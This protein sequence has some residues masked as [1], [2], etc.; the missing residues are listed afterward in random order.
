M[1]YN[2][3]YRKKYKDIKDWL[4]DNK[5]EL[6]VNS[7]NVACLREFKGINQELGRIGVINFFL[8]VKLDITDVRVMMN[9]AKKQ[10]RLVQAVCKD[11]KKYKVS[12]DYKSAFEYSIKKLKERLRHSFFITK[13]N[14][15]M[16]EYYPY[17]EQVGFD[18][19]LTFE[20]RFAEEEDTPI[21][22]LV[23]EIEAWNKEHKDE[24]KAHV[25]SVREE[26]EITE[27]FR[28]EKQE[29]TKQDKKLDRD[30][31]REQEKYENMI[32]K[33]Q[34][35]NLKRIRQQKEYDEKHYYSVVS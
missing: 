30:K 26:K 9:S 22:Y 7:L 34:Q 2:N 32:I 20:I 14:V 25:E 23:E 29:K 15:R 27:K 13:E 17:F 33:G 10:R 5:R 8:L 24:V 31:A 28:K 16:T 19:L 12:I 4:N 35:D 21:D 18:K 11:L 3:Y 1:G 6:G